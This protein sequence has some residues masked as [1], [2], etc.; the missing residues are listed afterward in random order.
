MSI[1]LESEEAA[2]LRMIERELPSTFA[3][4]LRIKVVLLCLPTTIYS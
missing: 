4:L 1:A 3:V 2:F